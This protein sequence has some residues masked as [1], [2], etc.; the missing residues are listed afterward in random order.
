[1]AI[2][3][4]YL[5]IFIGRVTRGLTWM[6]GVIL[7]M[8]FFSGLILAL[9]LCRPYA[10]K[11]D[12]TIHGTCGDIMA[13]YRWISIPSLITDFFI[14]VIPIPTIWKLQMNKYKKFG[15]FVTFLT[16]SL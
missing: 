2:L 12:K 16:G 11:W 8:F 10:F 9:A 6:M 13:G 14:L 1:M 15:L 3:T 5:K 4:L 7:A